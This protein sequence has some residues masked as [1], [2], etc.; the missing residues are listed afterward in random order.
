MS[1][2][3]EA[4]Q[5]ICEKLEQLR[6]EMEWS[7]TG[8][9]RRERIATAALQ[10]MIAGGYTPPF[11]KGYK[12]GE[13]CAIASVSFADALIAELDKKPT[14][15]IARNPNGSPCLADPPI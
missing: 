12:P 8:P 2:E 15:V 6:Q 10:G 7:S 14:Q 4:A 13:A 5:E 9:G 1:A 3:Y 11:V